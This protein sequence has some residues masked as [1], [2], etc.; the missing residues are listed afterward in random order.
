MAIAATLNEQIGKVSAAAP[1]EDR[2]LA[3]MVFANTVHRLAIVFRDDNP[4]FDANRF[5][6]ACGLEPILAAAQ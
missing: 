5:I 1:G 4:K 6:A 2:D 3:V